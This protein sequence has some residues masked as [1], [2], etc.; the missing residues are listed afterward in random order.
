MIS[1]PLSDVLF[2]IVF[3]GFWYFNYKVILSVVSVVV[4]NVLAMISGDAPIIRREDVREPI[5][6]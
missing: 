2:L 4:E 3:S 1:P 5:T 6:G